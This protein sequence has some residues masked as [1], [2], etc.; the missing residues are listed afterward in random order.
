MYPNADLINIGADQN[1]LPIFNIGTVRP[2]YEEWA[3]DFCE[4]TLSSA[5]PPPP[6]IGLA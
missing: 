3:S 5:I 2:S 6:Q 4:I 1:K